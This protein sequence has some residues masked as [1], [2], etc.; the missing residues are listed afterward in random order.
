MAR[1]SINTLLAFL[2]GGAAIAVLGDA[3]PQRRDLLLY[4]HSPSIPTGLY[5]RRQGPVQPGAIVTVRAIDVAP[6]AAAS[7]HF[8]DPGDRFIKRVAASAGD[9]VCAQ[10]D[11]LSVN[12]RRVVRRK[13]R[14][15]AGDVLPAWSGCRV[16]AGEELLLLGDTEDSFDGRYWGPTARGKIEGV[17]VPLS[18]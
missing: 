7:R 2:A 13:T 14:D 18:F 9:E 11:T 5:L 15:A 1:P 4:N 8:T 3:S 10:G 17:W 6:E 16:L 12:Q